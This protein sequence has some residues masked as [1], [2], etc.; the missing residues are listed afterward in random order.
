MPT[1]L[2]RL[3]GFD[4]VKRIL[5]KLGKG[6][7]LKGIM[8]AAVSDIKAGVAVYPSSSAANQPKQWT[9]GGNNTWYQRGFGSKWVRKD[10]SVGGSQT[11]QTLGRR[12]TTRVAAGGLRG[13]VGN[14]ATYGPFVQDRD[15]QAAFHKARGWIT[16]QDVAEQRADGIVAKVG[17][18]MDKI[19]AGQG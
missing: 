4:E 2:L 18:A 13:E 7:Y 9:S 10:G 14:A 5:D 19:I 16:I 6:D 12:W 11:S 1:L 15:V 8:Q 3:E 17:E